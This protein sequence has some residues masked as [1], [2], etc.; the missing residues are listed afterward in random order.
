MHLWSYMRL[1]QESEEEL[2]EALAVLAE[3]HEREPDIRATATLLAGWSR[4]HV[5]VLSALGERYKLG[6]CLEHRFETGAQQLFHGPRERRHGLLCDLHET[7]LLNQR[8]LLGWTVLEQA[9]RAL[10]HRDLV[11]ICARMGSES[12]RQLGWLRARIIEVA[13]QVLIASA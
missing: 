7:W 4:Q 2:A 8:V 9:A 6:E 1:L 13:P 10:C 12:D 3:Y 5:Q 11:A